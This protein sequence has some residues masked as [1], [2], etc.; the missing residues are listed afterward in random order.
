MDHSSQLSTVGLLAMFLIG[1][2]LA[3][4]LIAVL[5]GRMFG[6]SYEDNATLAFTTTAR[7]SEAVIGVAVSAFP[8]HPLVYLAI[9]LG[10]IVE[11]PMLLLIARMMLVL[12][13]R[14]GAAPA[15]GHDQA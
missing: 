7:N 4:F 9:I 5:A 1:F 10:P 13:D 12:K 6:L 2:F 14:I 8:G 15:V 3:L 11:L